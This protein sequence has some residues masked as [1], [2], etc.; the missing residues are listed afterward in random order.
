MGVQYL[1][2]AYYDAGEFHRGYV[3]VENGIVVETGTTPPAE[4]SVKGIIIPALW[5]CHTHV[6]D[7][8]IEPP[9]GMGLHE[10][11]SWPG[12]LK[13]RLHRETPMEKRST[14]VRRY[15]GSMEE[16]G[17]A[18]FVDF[19]EEGAT[20]TL[21]ESLNTLLGNWLIKHIK[22]VDQEFG[23]FLKEKGITIDE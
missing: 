23:T 22:A 11:V 19:R 8:Y 21:A 9:A 14:A 5:N 15:V 18:G 6:G 7:A 13:H 4:P 12:G 20:Y 17:T 1:A 10:L 16:Y 3:A 2:G